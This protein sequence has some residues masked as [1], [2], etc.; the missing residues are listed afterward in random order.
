[1]TTGFGFCPNCGAA[2]TEA[3]QRFCAACGFTL[4]GAAA[5][6]AVPP[7]A[8]VAPAPPPWAVPPGAP[9]G[10]APARTPISSTTLL[11]GALVIA[12]VVA[13]GF[14]AMNGSRPSSSASASN[15]GSLF[16]SS[17]PT[18]SAVPTASSVPAT[19]TQGT[20]GGIVTFKPSTFGCSDTSTQVTMSVWLPASVS[21]S[22]EVTGEFDGD[23]VSTRVV[24]DTF[25][26]QSD[27]RWLR[28]ET[29]SAAVICVGLDV[30]KHVYRVLDSEDKVLAQG[31]FT[32][33]GEAATPTPASGKG[34]LTVRPSSFSC[35]DTSTQVSITVLLPASLSASSEI[36]AM[37]DGEK[38][39]TDTVSGA[40][41]TKQSDGRWLSTDSDSA[42]NICS[43]YGAG[44]HTFS[45]LDA[46]DKVLASGSFTANP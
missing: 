4:S 20:G 5:S 3:G 41:F 43:A 7:P 21:E 1:M 34:S 11:I 35:S 17:V 19:P 42:S 6:A 12:A 37:L 40:G 39:S 2:L 25:K 30:G 15:G 36:T 13:V 29:D 16:G 45:V 44:K 46:Q 31:S 10:A 27:G 32:L 33:T 22:D 38:G 18:T 8:P 24:G 26:K 28:S 14:F 23:T 9:V